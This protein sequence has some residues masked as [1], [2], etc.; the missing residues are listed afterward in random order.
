MKDLWRRGNRPRPWRRSPVGSVAGAEQAQGARLFEQRA[1]RPGIG[2]VLDDAVGLPV[3]ERPK[4]WAQP[5]SLTIAVCWNEV[6]GS[7]R[8]GT[9][10]ELSETGALAGHRVLLETVG[11][12]LTDPE[13]RVGRSG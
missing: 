8:M 5:W 9:T 1:P 10:A 13:R 2:H 6:T 12:V 11:G 7:V 4:S 3:P